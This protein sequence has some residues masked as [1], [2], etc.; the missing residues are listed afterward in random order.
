MPAIELTDGF[1][2]DA[3]VAPGVLSS[4][5]K[6][7]ENEVR[8]GFGDFNLSEIQQLGLDHSPAGKSHAG[9]TFLEPVDIGLPDL[10]LKIGAGGT[11]TL[12]VLLA[13]DNEGLASDIFGDPLVIAADRGYVSFTLAANVSAALSANAGEVHFGFKAASKVQL[14]NLRR[15][16]LAPAPSILS[17]VTDTLANFI[18]PGDL[19][20]IQA[21]EPGTVCAVDG[22]GS[23]KLS[24]SYD[25]DFLTNPLAAVDLPLAPGAIRITSGG[26]VSVGASLTLTGEYQFRVTRLDGNRTR[27][28]VYRK[29]ASELDVSVTPS[30]GLT[31]NIGDTEII[32]TVLSKICADPKADLKS[33]AA[34]GLDDKT[35]DSIASAIKA[36]VQRR[37]E[38]AVE[39]ELA[40]GAEHDAA[41]LYDLDCAALDDISQ[42]AVERALKGDFSAISAEGLAGV[43]L[44]RSIHHDVRT[45]TH[46]LSVNLLGIFNFSSV[47]ELVL[48][49]KVLYEAETGTLLITDRA[50]A[51]RIQAATLNFAADPEKLRRLYAESFMITAA[52]R[53]SR[54]AI[55]DPALTS[56]H[57]VFLSH[58][59]TNRQAMHDM[60]NVPVA[61]GLASAL[62]ASGL[63]DGL[64]DFGHSSLFAENRFDEAL[65]KKLFLQGSKARPQLEYERAGRAALGLMIAP[66]DPDAYR[67]VLVDRDEVWNRLKE[68]G[69]PTEFHTALPRLT[70]VQTA[71]VG[72][73]YILLIW[74]AE[75]MSSM[76]AI[77]EKFEAFFT[78]NP[79]AGPDHPQFQALRAKL[80]KATADV[81]A[82]TKPEFG[83]PWGFLAMD[84]VL[85]PES[86]ARVQLTSKLFSVE[87]QR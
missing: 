49:G 6:Y 60:L 14:T 32:S 13:R 70:N 67:R 10:H 83:R 35:A 56:A 4:V 38:L 28:G 71:T 21:L 51:S 64:N 78:A 80:A 50:T 18:I 62:E 74:W 8:L 63:L 11:A 23:L 36:G 81:A 48:A 26:S 53:G 47:T 73:D 65:C 5:S 40:S 86:K 42:S 46:S 16:P 77:L 7:F 57:T 27:L 19:A 69:N 33:L 72:S 3:S 41:F 85:F 66:G 84:R 1:G 82:K 76:A 12:G 31:A 2:L 9:L 29:K 45:T 30:F 17:A 68:L 44:V 25:L 43:T 61:L 54:T 20:D 15:F 55:A 59:A 52:Y 37:L 24:G 58:A 75:S 79:D 39:A 34:A 87:R 22:T